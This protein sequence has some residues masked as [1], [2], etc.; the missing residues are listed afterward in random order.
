MRWKLLYN[1]PLQTRR[2]GSAGR[3]RRRSFLVGEKQLFPGAAR[4]SSRLCRYSGRRLHA[5]GTRSGE[6]SRSFRCQRADRHAGYRCAFS[7]WQRPG[8][9][10][11]R[12][13]PARVDSNGGFCC[14]QK[15][16]KACLLFLF[17]FSFNSLRSYG[18]FF[19]GIACPS[20]RERQRGVRPEPLRPGFAGFGIPAN[21]RF[22]ADSATG[23]ALVTGRFSRRIGGIFPAAG[24]WSVFCCGDSHFPAA[25]GPGP[26]GNS[27]AILFQ[28][29]A[30]PDGIRPGRQRGFHCLQYRKRSVDSGTA[31]FRR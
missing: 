2:P 6:A 22:S 30:A 19:A 3:R 25:R 13:G 18:T 24:P 11:R 9:G 7:P 16:G 28:Q 12:F 31:P 4:L 27:N 20:S 10:Q 8:L 21:G 23:P 17:V 5:F 1:F 15:A 29:H 26:G 14:R